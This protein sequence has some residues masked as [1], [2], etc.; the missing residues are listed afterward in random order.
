MGTVF[1]AS[2][3]TRRVSGATVRS[4]DTGSMDR[5]G[6]GD[7]Q[8]WPDWSVRQNVPGDRA[9]GWVLAPDAHAAVTIANRLVGP[10]GGWRIGPDV[11]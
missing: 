9:S 5:E 1:G 8:D 11:V 6:P 2:G 10:T 4:T 7:T 3:D